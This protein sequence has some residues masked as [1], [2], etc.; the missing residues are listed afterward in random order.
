MP[1]RNKLPENDISRID[2]RAAL[3]REKIAARETLASAEQARRSVA[4]EAHLADAPEA[5][6]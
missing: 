4:L 3:R 6:P 5:K 1:G 2:A